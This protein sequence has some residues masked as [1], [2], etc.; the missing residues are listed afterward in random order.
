MTFDPAAI[1]NDIDGYLAKRE[2]NY[3][4]IKPGA[5]KQMIW[6]D[7]A[8]KSKSPYSVVYI[9][10]F[11]A[12]LAEVRPVPDLVAKEIGANL[13]YTRLTG[14]GRTGDAMAEAKVNDWYNDVAEAL[15]IGRATG[16]KVIVIATST[17]G[18]LATWAATQPK[19]MK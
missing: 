10:G 5:Q 12:S 18:T 19:L 11:S 8:T 1:G 15:A 16:G 14:H 7:P 2:A 6:L 13:F 17:G 9:H 3:S 4:D